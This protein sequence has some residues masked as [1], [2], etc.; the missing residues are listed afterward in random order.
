MVYI[1]DMG[2]YELQPTL[3]IVGR[4]ITYTYTLKA[5]VAVYKYICIPDEPRTEE[6]ESS[7]V[8]LPKGS[9]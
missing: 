1:W 8:I 9:T 2:L 6:D 7:E 3:S 4:H 5:H